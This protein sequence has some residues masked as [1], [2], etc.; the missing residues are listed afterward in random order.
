M[1]LKLVFVLIIHM[2]LVKSS[3][4]TVTLKVRPVQQLFCKKLSFTADY[5]IVF[6]QLFL[7]RDC[8]LSRV[9]KTTCNIYTWGGSARCSDIFLYTSKN[10]VCQYVQIDQV[11]INDPDADGWW[12]Q[13]H[14][15]VCYHIFI[16][17]SNNNVTHWQEHDQIIRPS[18]HIW[19]IHAMQTDQVWDKNGWKR[20]IQAS[21][22]PIL[23]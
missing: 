6:I 16:L 20:K 5:T 11:I 9:V 1:P 8:L 13:H 22:Q 4:L 21:Y 2:V 18:H 3:G 17:F 14:Y 7:V 15:I 10:E 23:H 12:A 19:A